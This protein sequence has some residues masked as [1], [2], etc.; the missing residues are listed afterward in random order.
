MSSAIKKADIK[1]GKMKRRFQVATVALKRDNQKLAIY[2]CFGLLALISLAVRKSL[3]NFE[4]GD[5]ISAFSPWY[6]F[7]KLHGLH[8]F[9]YGFSN[10]NPPY[11]YFLYLTTLLP[12]SKIHAVKGLLIVFDLLLAYSV[13]LVVTVVNK[14]QYMAL[15]AGLIT[16]FLPSVLLNGVLWGQFDNF[17]TSF[18]MLSLYF[19]LKKN[20][21]WAWIF[22]GVA[23]AIKLQAIFFLPVLVIMVFKRIK[24]Y[25]AYWSV[26]V[27]IVLTFPPVLVGR[28]LGSIIS[29]YTSQTSLYGGNLTLNAPNWYQ[30]ITHS[31]PYAY[32]TNI[33]PYFNGAGVCLT[34]AAVTFIFIYNLINK[35]YGQKD[36]MLL[37][38][39]MLF[40]V[41]FLLPQMHDRYFFPAGIATLVLAFAYPVYASVAV[42]MQVLL[43]FTYS[44]YLFSMFPLPLSVVAVFIL[45]IICVLAVGYMRPE[46]Q[47]IKGRKRSPSYEK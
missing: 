25:D 4:T 30:W 29:I 44:P 34:L 17:Y 21:R 7:L 10:Y 6:D 45:L 3:I 8:G 40:L 36:V 19:L 28:S 5:Y 16:L 41:P 13:Y 2:I 9:K 31:T 47:A 15:I 23:I 37:S 1:T 42:L 46:T 22:F 39:L 24:W 18:L 32:T 12:I 35:K 38:T 14:R 11:T 43:I 26:L 27:F 33:F 20:S